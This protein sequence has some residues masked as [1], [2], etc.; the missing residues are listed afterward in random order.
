M[1]QKLFES[2]H[3]GILVDKMQMNMKSS[4]SLNKFPWID[5]F[6]PWKWRGYGTNPI[7]TNDTSCCIKIYIGDAVEISTNDKFEIYFPI[8]LQSQFRLLGEECRQRSVYRQF[9]ALYTKF[10]EPNG[11]PAVLLEGPHGHY[12]DWCGQGEK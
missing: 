11:L 8:L 4:S 5:E 2:H 9:Y 10:E 7:G 12:V 6:G 1:L 3:P